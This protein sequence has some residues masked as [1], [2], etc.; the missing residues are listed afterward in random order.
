MANIDR[1]VNV[2]IALRTAGI[3]Q[4]T[5]SDLMLFGPFTKPSGSTANVYVIT[6]PDELINTYG[7][8]VDDEIYLAAETF[9]S[10]IPHPPQ[11]YIGFDGGG[12]D[13]TNALIAINNENSDWYGICDVLHDE[14][15]T[16]KIAEWVEAQEKLFVTVLSSPNNADAAAGDTTSI[17]HL[18]MAGN[19]FRTAWW[20]DTNI[21]NFPDV[22]IASKSFTKYPGQETWANQRLD[23]VSYIYLPEGTFL[24]ITD[25][26]GNTFEPFRNISITQNG[27]VAGGEWIDVIRFRDWLCEQIKVTIFMQMVDNRIPFTDPG[28]AVIR[29]R[30]QQALDFG[31]ARGGIA[32][33]EVND[34]GDYVPSYTIQV[35]LS[36]DVPTNDK[37][38]RI[39]RDVYFTA[40]LAGAIHAVQIQGTLTYENLPVASPQSAVNIAS[41]ASRAQRQA[42]DANRTN[43]QASVQV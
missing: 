24:N 4:A 25:K 19:F 17:A 12:A 9:F 10:Q 15:R 37:A 29:S 40:R 5:F 36:V 13:P 16:I 7:C 30:L 18:L 11:L 6:D 38:N 8:T 33:P 20:Y 23:A 26:N 34:N 35:P 3:T 31:V 32:P 28:I 27:K 42:A 2:T 21:E 39:L 22:G 1:I 43:R 41:A 14:A